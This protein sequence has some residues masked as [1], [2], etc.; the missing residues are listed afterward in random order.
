MEI[1]LPGVSGGPF[2]AAGMGEEDLLLVDLRRRHK[3]LSEVDCPRVGV[4]M[5][6]F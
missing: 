2:D 5:V 6:A 1:T 3:W 4:G